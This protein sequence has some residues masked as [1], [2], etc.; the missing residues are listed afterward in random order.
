MSM[1]RELRHR[2]M[3]KGE[4]KYYVSIK[5]SDGQR[6]KTGPYTYE[7]ALTFAAQLRRASR[8]EKNPASKKEITVVGTR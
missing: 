4:R 1:R 2:G 6:T 8:Q 3:S 5:H 7:D